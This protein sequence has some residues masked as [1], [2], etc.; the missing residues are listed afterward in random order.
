MNTL[1]VLLDGAADEKIPELGGRTPLESL[2][3]RFIDS[4]ATAGDFG[5]ETPWKN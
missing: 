3:K 5:T 1:V 4:V 2:D